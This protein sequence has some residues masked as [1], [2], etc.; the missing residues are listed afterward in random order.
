MNLGSVSR[1]IQRTRLRT[2]KLESLC[3][4]ANYRK[5]PDANVEEGGSSNEGKTNIAQ[6]PAERDDDELFEPI[7]VVAAVELLPV[8]CRH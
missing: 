8:Q 7:S 1:T 5:I 6:G 4:R 2:F 3:V